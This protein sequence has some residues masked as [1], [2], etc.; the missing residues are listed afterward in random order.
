M[1]NDHLHPSSL[2]PIDEVAI[3][4][5]RGIEPNRVSEYMHHLA[6]APSVR[7]DGAAAQEIASLWRALP[8][9]EMMRC[10]T[11][12]FGVRFSAAGR[13]V[14]EASLCWRCNNAFGFVGGRQIS[15]V[16]DGAAEVS[17]KLLARFDELLPGRIT[18]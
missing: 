15:F 4:P 9:G 7:P 13:V 14:V 1:P 12:P 8:P 18:D 5:L 16:F 17:R 6:G 2:P 10:H 11:P 3:F